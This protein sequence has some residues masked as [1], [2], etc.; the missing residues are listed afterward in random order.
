MET[1]SSPDCP[2]PDLLGSRPRMQSVAESP[3]PPCPWQVPSHLARPPSPPHSRPGPFSS[4]L[5]CC[6]FPL[7]GVWVFVVFLLQ[8]AGSV[9]SPPS[10]PPPRAAGRAIAAEQNKSLAGEQPRLPVSFIQPRSRQYLH[11]IL[12][13]SPIMWGSSCLASCLDPPVPLP[14]SQ[15]HLLL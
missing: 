13:N 4:C 6:G 12:F 7:A 3:G 1:P 2:T 5:F 11:K 14:P 15:K 9:P 8:M 10:P